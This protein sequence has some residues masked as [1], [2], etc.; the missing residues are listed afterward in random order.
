MIEAAKSMAGAVKA[1]VDKRLSQVIASIDARIK[2]VADS[3][4]EAINGKDGTD[5][6]DGKDGTDGVNGIDGK[7]GENG[8]NGKDGEKGLD[9]LNG[10]DGN[11]GSDGRDALSI[12]ILPTIVQGKSYHRGSF[13]SWKGGLVRAM[14]NTDPMM[15]ADILKAGWA[16]VVNGVDTVSFVQGEDPRDIKM[17]VQTTEKLVEFNARVPVMAYKGIFQPSEFLQGDSVTYAG[18][19]WIAEKDGPVG[20]P[21]EPGSDG[22]RLA[23]KRGRDGKDGRNGI[24]MTKPVHV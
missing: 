19:L 9:G 16:V 21:G 5:G 15:D 20:K 7:N 22:W 24:D 8:L 6:K 10:K 17:V 14:R 23:V 1:Y 2:E 13:A 12:E 11:D 3:V 4:P 18:S